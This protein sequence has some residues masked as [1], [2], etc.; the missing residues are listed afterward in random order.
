MRG[1]ISASE[2][3]QEQDGVRSALRRLDKSHWREF[4]AA[5]Q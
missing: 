5:W 3:E 4:L 1:E 2:C